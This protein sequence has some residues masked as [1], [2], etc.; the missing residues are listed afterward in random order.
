MKTAV[1][2][3]LKATRKPPLGQSFALAGPEMLRLEFVLKKL[4]LWTGYAGVVVI[5]GGFLFLLLSGQDTRALPWYILLSPWVCVFF[6]LP[7]AQQHA[8]VGWFI[9]KFRR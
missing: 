5:Y 8:V 3:S 1:K 7:S 9:N 4:M 6:G 2:F